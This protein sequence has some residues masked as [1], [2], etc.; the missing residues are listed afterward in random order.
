MATY[1]Y[2]HESELYHYGILGMHW[3]V[4]RFQNKDGTLTEAGKKRYLTNNG[5][6]TD[7]GKKA[8]YNRHGT[9]SKAGKKY[10]NITGDYG[11]DAV[12]KIMEIRERERK[13]KEK[14]DKAI[15]RCAKELPKYGIYQDSNDDFKDWFH[16]DFKRTDIKGACAQDRWK[17]HKPQITYTVSANDSP[18]KVKTGIDKAKSYFIKN[19]TKIRN[20]VANNM[21]KYYLLWNEDTFAE[22]G[23]KPISKAEFAKKLQFYSIQTSEHGIDGIGFMDDDMFFGHEL[24]YYN[25]K[26]VALEG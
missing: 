10:Y 24:W 25:D 15:N 6:L 13:E 20:A 16:K 19:E 2:N 3:G 17:Q 21:Y 14:L 26:N 4:R 8:F 7:K 1:Y 22:T 18:E 11:E 12:N 5:Q 23:A 9:L